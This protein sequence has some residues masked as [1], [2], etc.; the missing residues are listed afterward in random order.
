[1]CYIHSP[2]HKF[3]YP[4]GKECCPYTAYDCSLGRERDDIIKLHRLNGKKRTQITR[5]AVTVP[6]GGWLAVDGDKKHHTIA[7]KFADGRNY[8]GTQIEYGV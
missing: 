3:I 4:G 2:F 1:S 8:D 6:V 7:V 5:L